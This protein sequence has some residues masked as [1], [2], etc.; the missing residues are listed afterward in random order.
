MHIYLY[1]EE[2]LAHPFL[3]VQYMDMVLVMI[4]VILAIH[5]WFLCYML[6]IYLF[7]VVTILLMFC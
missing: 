3:V 4:A 2:M 5:C 6:C 1:A 7:L